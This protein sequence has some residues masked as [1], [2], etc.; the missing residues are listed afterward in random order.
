MGFCS[1]SVIKCQKNHNFLL[2][3]FQNIIN[4]HCYKMFV[5]ESDIK[6]FIV[7]N[8][9]DYYDYILIKNCLNLIFVFLI[10]LSKLKKINNC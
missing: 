4:K 10:Q 6:S 3:G 9:N 2:T 5:H 8:Y 1:L 7:Y